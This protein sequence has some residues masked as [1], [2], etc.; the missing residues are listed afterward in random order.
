M[1]ESKKLGLGSMSRLKPSGMILSLL[2]FKIEDL[3]VFRIF[4]RFLHFK[5]RRVI[6]QRVVEE[7]GREFHSFRQFLPYRFDNLYPQKLKMLLYHFL[8]ILYWAFDKNNAI[9]AR[10]FKLY[11]F[12]NSLSCF[13]IQISVKLI[14]LCNCHF[15]SD[16][17]A[18]NFWSV[19]K[20]FWQS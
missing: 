15:Q 16:F 4:R 17:M 14:E 8:T 6:I 20:H 11:Q 3:E 12:V 13:K 10:V 7:S 9:I 2:L 19:P 18:W 5:F 1:E